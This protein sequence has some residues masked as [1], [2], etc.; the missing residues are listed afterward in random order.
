MAERVG[1]LTNE[2]EELL[3]NLLEEC[4]EVMQELGKIMRF[5]PSNHHPT[6]RP[7]MR[8]LQRLAVEV[9]NLQHVI[10]ELERSRTLDHVLMATGRLAKQ[11]GMRRWAIEHDTTR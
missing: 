8:N 11:D 1:H 5:G 6:D 4:G 2:A 9:G 3:G 10:N 7:E